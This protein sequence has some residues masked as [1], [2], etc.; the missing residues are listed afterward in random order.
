M[1]KTIEY[2]NSLLNTNDRIIIGVSGGIDSICLLHIINSLKEK[3]KLHIVVAHINHNVRKESGYDEKFVKKYCN[4]LNIR[5]ESI[6]IDFY[7]GDNFQNEARKIR[8]DFF[9][10]LIKKY[11]SNYLMTA[12]HGD[13]L[14]ETILMRI[15]RGSTLKGYSGFSIKNQKENY[16][17]IKPLIFVSKEEIL[18]YINNNDLKYCTDTSNDTDDYTRNRY[19]HHVIPFL[20]EENKDVHEQFLKFHNLLEIHDEYFKELVNEKMNDMYKDEKLDLISFKKL[21]KLIKIKIIEQLLCSIYNDEIFLINTEHI[22]L[23]LNLINKDGNSSVMLP[24]NMLAIKSYDSLSI[25]KKEERNFYNIEISHFL[26]SE[27]ELPNGRKIQI[28]DESDLT[29]NFVTRI[30]TSEIDYPIYIRTRKEG[31]KMNVKNM[32]G[33]KKINDIFIDE[34]ISKKD[35]E[36]WPVVVDSGNKIIWLPGIKKSKFDKEKS[37]NYDIILKYQ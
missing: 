19:R 12:H 27:I 32:K 6:T 34:K 26:D 1:K 36:Q 13:D 24:N 31:D 25:E 30:D 7:K 35:R 21:D 15:S 8:Y 17:I 14:I 37:E 29:D 5:F 20:K 9:E 16:Q 28:L 2:L 23:I 10:K 4:E 11:K 18:E 3:Y 22:K 33:S